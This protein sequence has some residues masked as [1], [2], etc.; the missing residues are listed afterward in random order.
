MILYPI[1]RLAYFSFD[2]INV[3]SDMWMDSEMLSVIVIV[4]AVLSL[5]VFKH[6]KKNFD[7]ENNILT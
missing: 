6:I 3:V 7:A 2:A 1:G 4:I 5:P